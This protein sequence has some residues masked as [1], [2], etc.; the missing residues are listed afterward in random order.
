MGVSFEFIIFEKKKNGVATVNLNNPE[1]HNAFHDKMI[2]E[3]TTVLSD[4]EKCSKTNVVILSGEGKSFSAGA[5]LNWMKRA[6]Q[7]SFDENLADSERLSDM[8][9][10]LY[11]LKQLTIACVQGAVMGGGLGLVACCDIVIAQENAKFALSEVKLGLIPSTISPFVIMAIGSR[12]AKRYFQTGELIDVHRAQLIGLVHDITTSPQHTA[13]ILKD[14][15]KNFMMSAPNAAKSA[16]KLVLD[17]ANVQITDD[18]RKES[19]K[20]IA[21]IR[22]SD[23]AKDG[24]GAFFEK[25]KAD[26]VQDV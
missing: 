14:I 3:L 25:R 17:F 7:Y 5:D 16:K 19:A 24:L 13:E 12:Q 1:I 18:L 9:N 6:A 2:A 22:S 23:E 8:L 20:R 11:N 21:Q 10:K 26:W 4:L 15:M